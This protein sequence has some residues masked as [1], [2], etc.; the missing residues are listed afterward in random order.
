MRKILY[1]KR[2]I[3]E[4]SPVQIHTSWRVLISI[5]A[6]MA[7]TAFGWGGWASSVRDQ[8]TDRV[9]KIT[10]EQLKTRPSF[11][12]VQNLLYQERQERREENREQRVWFQKVLDDRIEQLKYLIQRSN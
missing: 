8:V 3:S 4:N 2:H 11:G 10:D 5:L 1:W 12:E 6:M 9:V 7:L